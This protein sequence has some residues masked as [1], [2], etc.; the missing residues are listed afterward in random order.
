MI[1]GQDKKS[2]C[3]VAGKVGEGTVCWEGGKGK[4][5]GSGS[6][7]V[8]RARFGALMLYRYPCM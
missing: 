4:K 5:E 6:Q 3:K 8:R 1:D 2:M 7:C